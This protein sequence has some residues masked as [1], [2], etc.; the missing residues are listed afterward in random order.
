MVP[1]TAQRQAYRD[2]F[3]SL[4]REEFQSWFE[5]LA[6]AL[7]E[8]GDFQ[9]IRQTSGDGGLDGLVIGSGLAYQ[10]YAPARMDDLRDGEMAA[11]MRTDFARAQSSLGGRLQAWRFVHNHPE[12]K[13][14]QLTAA[15]V[16]DLQMGNPDVEIKI[17]DIDSLWDLL[18]DNLSEASFNR[19][20]PREQAILDRHVVESHT[21]RASRELLRIRQR[22]VAVPPAESRADVARL[23][24][25][26]SGGDLQHAESDVRSEVLYW[27]AR[28][29]A[30]PETLKQAED[31]RQ[32]LLQQ[33]APQDTSVLD[34]LL[35]EAGGDAEG[36]RRKLRDVNDP[37]ARATLLAMLRRARRPADALDWFDSCSNPQVPGFFTGLG[38]YNLV[39]TLANA[40]RW[41]DARGYL[42]GS[43]DLWDEW[44]DLPLLDG[45]V[46]AAL[47][48]PSEFRPDALTT[49]PFHRVV[50]PIEGPDA[51]LYRARATASFQDAE[52]RW[53]ELHPP[54]ALAARMWLLWLR[55]TSP[56]AQ[57][58]AAARAEVQQSMTEGESMLRLLPVATEY[59]I[60]FDV[61]TAWR[62]LAQRAAVGGLNDEELHAQLILAEL[63]LPPP[64]FLAYLDDEEARLV[65]G[66]PRARLVLARVQ[67]LASTGQT[68][69]ART[70][71]Q[72]ERTLFADEEF[73]RLGGLIDESEGID[74]RPQLEASYAQTNSLL[75][76]N[77]LIGHLRRVR[78]W[79]A[80]RPLLVELFRLDRNRPNALRLVESMYHSHAPAAE[81]LG[82]L[83]A[84]QDLVQGEQDLQSAQAW[85]LFQAGRLEEA[86]RLNHQLLSQR[87][88]AEDLDLDI[89]LALASGKWERFSEIVEREW[90]QRENHRPATLLRLA[91]LV[92]GVEVSSH[93][94]W[95]LVKLA[96]QKGGTDPDIMASALGLKFKL[97]R[98][99]D[100]ETAAWITRALE[101]SSDAGPLWKMDLTT[102]VQEWMP[103][104]RRRLREVEEQWLR[105]EIP[106]HFAAAQLNVPLCHLLIALPRA[107]AG[108]HDGRRR[109]L[110]PIISGAR[111][112]LSI[113]PG[114]T[115]GLDATSLLVLAHL[116]LLRR[117]IAALSKVC[118]APA[119]LPLLLN[120]RNQVR[121]HQ[122][123]RVKAAEALR[124]LLAGGAL[125]D[126]A[127]PTS[128]PATLA[129]E[130]GADLAQLLQAARE[131]GGTVVRP[132][133]VYRLES[134]MTET[135]T[136]GEYENLIC[137]TVDLEA[138]LFASRLVTAHLHE[139]AAGYL[140]SQDRPGPHDHGESLLSR[141]LY[142]DELAVT[143]LQTA[144]LLQVLTAAGL[145]LRVHASLREDTDRLIADSRHGEELAAAIDEVR[146]ALQKGIEEGK[147]ELL[148]RHRSPEEEQR[149]V[150]IA[151]T[152]IEFLHDTGTCDCLCV[153]D[154]Y[155]NRNATLSDRL[156]RSVPVVCVLDLLRVL[157]NGGTLQPAEKASLVHQLRLS[158]FVFV[159]VTP[160]EF[161][162]QLSAAP[163]RAD[164]SLAES[165][166][167]RAL[168]QSLA[169][170]RALEP[171]HAPNEQI[172]AVTLQATSVLVIHQLW[173]DPQLPAERAAKLA[174]WVW[175]HVTPRPRDLLGRAPPD[176]AQATE[177]VALQL[178]Q[179]L[180]AWPPIDARR[181]QAF[182]E[183]LD[184]ALL[185]PLLPAHPEVVP[186]VAES[187]GRRIEH[188]TSDL[189]D[190]A[191]RM[192]GFLFSRLPQR[193]RGWLAANFTFRQE[194]GLCPM[195]VL[196][197]GGVA[198]LADTPLFVAARRL[199]ATQQDQELS[200]V[201]GRRAVL[202]MR[203]GVV[204]L[205][206]PREGEDSLHL[207]L[208]QLNVLAPDGEARLRALD[209]LLEQL[210]ASS[211]EFASMRQAAELRAL[212]DEEVCELFEAHQKA[213]RPRQEGLR[214]K[215]ATHRATLDDLAPD[216][217]ADYETFC[218]PDPAGVEPEPYLTSV[219]PDSRQQ[220]LRRDP[221]EGLRICLLGALRDDL[222]PGRWLEEISDDLLWSSLQA[223]QPEADPF[224][225]LAALDVALYRQHDARFVGF[226]ENAVAAL[227]GDEFP[228]PN[229]LDFYRLFSL[230]VE[231]V[232]EKIN[233]LEGGALRAP[234]WK[235]MCAWM[236]AVQVIR[237]TA[238][239]ALDLDALDQAISDSLSPA[240]QDAKL[241]DLRKEPM[242]HPGQLS[243]PSVRGEVLRRLLQLARRHQAAGPTVP[244]AD[245]IEQVLVGD[246]QDGS[247]L[248]WMLPGPL[249][250]HQNAQDGMPE[251]LRD[252][253]GNL[254]VEELPTAL[255]FYSRRFQLPEELR[256]RLRA[257]IA[258]DR[259]PDADLGQQLSR[260][261]VA[262]LVAA[263]Q[264]DRE[265]AD[266]VGASTAALA[267]ALREEAEVGT[268]FHCLVIAAAALP[269]EAAWAQWLKDRFAEVA[270]RVP[271][272]MVAR[273]YWHCLQQIRVVTRLHLGI[274]DRAEIV[275]SAAM[276]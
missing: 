100:K 209:D 190:D 256:S 44:P 11:K 172:F 119:T 83:E 267:P 21:D 58:R 224:S 235:R 107:N 43:R 275:A 155:L 204:F 179:L 236:Q 110:I 12:A 71:A 171:L 112:A 161:V 50:R 123:A 106:I 84:N 142:L 42:D 215:L 5:Q 114:W 68:S 86:E 39:V 145:E 265:L 63:K 60:P 147:V 77:N 54:R 124:D 17:L 120:E 197:L 72:E 2:N 70:L 152:I 116:G 14:G 75:D 102:V 19:L 237:L 13:I 140:R 103:A 15:A 222:C 51:D 248:L 32:Q 221:V 65:H 230:L 41:D 55:L 207:A 138:A 79:S 109:T 251:A 96:V 240:G 271:P 185:R 151:P 258:V 187:A 165:A 241:V 69:K 108:L 27:A 132:L 163:Q 125:P 211:R 113:Q 157:E 30:T 262:A 212:S 22:R 130:I 153:D 104:H 134:L 118:I 16:Q 201:E 252:Q 46:H 228:T 175:H 231:L 28:L 247:P 264:R 91:S 122:P 128:V 129:A 162:S 273:I 196:S 191:P 78:D 73:Q 92:A 260:L 26:L 198:S 226:A 59:D 180:D 168:R 85:A 31:F 47:L 194:L 233:S 216:A 270:A 255:L 208:Q 218:G 8:P 1:T 18:V 154:R 250:G 257:A 213:V 227:T 219:L 183:W 276:H 37:D 206:L 234:V 87:S 57:V 150:E 170:L 105:G 94:A 146:V 169:R 61:E 56:D 81:V 82:L 167:L 158:G 143:Y 67:A 225:L 181:H 217:L 99:G 64:D 214:D 178:M 254:P 45:V 10:V 126:A 127:A 149:V 115:V 20:F 4:F 52:A 23:A 188:L 93:R 139:S 97:G 137:S 144:G 223:C 193:I 249:E 148:P 53:R 62:Y 274:E 35:L 203:E 242:L 49:F 101:L 253:L 266:A 7:H 272:G 210:G 89:N 34:A 269:D 263:G 195:R 160:S 220:L 76:L 246:G 173:G 25:R 48:L 131:S 133:P 176:A 90:P 156:G 141:P 159:P 166:E 111:Q 40:E 38:W 98:E 88:R 199:L 9:P 239:A 121:F 232:L 189:G 245:Q 182:L 243:A 238:H 36:A 136:L 205:D 261:E 74:P 24:A 29:H 268:L 192:A 200:T 244:Q 229:G 33:A 174:S 117:V 95:E 202:T 3:R 6:R 177:A 186:R 135:A 259:G 184:H 80:L 66:V 164:G